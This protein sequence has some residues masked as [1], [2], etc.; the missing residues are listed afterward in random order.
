[1]RF[2]REQLK[3]VKKEGLLRPII[4]ALLITVGVIIASYVIYDQSSDRKAITINL[5]TEVIGLVVGGIVVAIIFELILENRS[6]KRWSTT[7]VAILQQLEIHYRAI[8]YVAR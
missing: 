5:L 4:L 1:M 6:E 2:W 3:S 7:R 8:I